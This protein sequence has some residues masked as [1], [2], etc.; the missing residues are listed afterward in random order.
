M[1]TIVEAV[2]GELVKDGT[3][4]KQQ[5]ESTPDDPVDRYEAT[6]NQTNMQGL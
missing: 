3:M 6:Q 5:K 1:F 2:I 4:L